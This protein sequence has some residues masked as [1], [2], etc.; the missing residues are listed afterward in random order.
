MST[1]TKAKPHPRW[2]DPIHANLIR[3]KD[4][5]IVFPKDPVAIAWALLFE[6]AYHFDAV[7]GDSDLVLE[8]LARKGK[9]Q[10]PQK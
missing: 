2:T 8:L 9:W 1:K 5:N 10:P 7:T 4:G 6:A 3:D